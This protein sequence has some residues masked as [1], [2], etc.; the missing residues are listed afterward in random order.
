MK[1]YFR[2]CRPDAVIPQRATPDS[3]GMDLTACVD[4]PVTIEPGKRALIPTGLCAA[5][6]TNDVVLL[7]YGRSGLAVKHGITLANAV[8][9]VDADYRGEI[10][11]PLINLGAEPFTVENGM[12]IAQLVVSPVLLPECVAADTLPDTIRGAGGFGSTGVS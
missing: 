12:R 11:V 7:I 8:G 4:A 10:C 9:V 6:E 1:L 5:P 2:K 3:A